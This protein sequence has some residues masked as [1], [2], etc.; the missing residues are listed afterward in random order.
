ML[1]ISGLS[2]VRSPVTC[3]TAPHLRTAAQLSPGEEMATMAANQRITLLLPPPG[4]QSR[5]HMHC[6]LLFLNCLPSLS[7]L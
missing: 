4:Q 1:T 7:P 5:S 2:I 6:L 3:G